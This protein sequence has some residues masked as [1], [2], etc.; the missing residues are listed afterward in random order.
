VRKV[1]GGKNGADLIA[2]GSFES[3]IP[4]LLHGTVIPK[5]TQSVWNG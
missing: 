2:V 3:A 5:Q 1:S 4:F